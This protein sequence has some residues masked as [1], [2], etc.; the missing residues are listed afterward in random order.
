MA[1]ILTCTINTTEN[2]QMRHYLSDEGTTYP[3]HRF[4]PHLHDDVEFYVLLDGDTSFMVEHSLYH[5]KSGDVIVTIPNEMHNCVLNT[6]SVHKHLCFWFS[7]PNQFLFDS[8]LNRP[9][10]EG[11]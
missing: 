2:L 1:H 7:P 5:L 6:Q 9:F 11:N 4:P 3:A 10:G 8:F